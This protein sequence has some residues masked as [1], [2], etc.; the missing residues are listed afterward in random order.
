MVLRPLLHGRVDLR[1]IHGQVRH[2]SRPIVR[3][4]HSVH[5]YSGKA[6]RRVAATAAAVLLNVIQGRQC[7]WVNAIRPISRAV[8]G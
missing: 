2:K 7:L 3:R 8:A 6:T 4:F 1:L 5:F